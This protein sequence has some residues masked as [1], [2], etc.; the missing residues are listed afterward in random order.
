MRVVERGVA[1]GGLPRGSGAPRR[2]RAA[3]GR[4]RSR[5]RA[6]SGSPRRSAAGSGR[7][8]RRRR[9]R[10]P[11]SPGAACGGSSCPG[12][13]PARAPRSSASSTVVLLDVE[14]GVEGADPDPQLVAGGE[15]TSRSRRA[16]SG[17][18]S[19]SRGPR[20][21]RRGGPRGRARAARRAA[22][23]R[24]R[25]QHRGASRA[26]RRR[27]AREIVPRS[28]STAIAP[29]PLAGAARPFTLAVSNVG[30]AVAP[31]QLAELAVVEGREGPGEAVA[32]VAVGGVH[33]QRAE[34]LALGV[35]QAQSPA[36]TR[37]GCRRPRSGA[38]RSRS[39][40]RPARRRPS[41]PARGRPP[42]RRSW[43]RRSAR[44][45]CRRAASAR[46]RAWSLAPASTREGI[47]P[48]SAIIRRRVRD[49]RH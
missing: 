27:A 45:G 17:G 28:V 32:G 23:S 25:G 24:R 30:V 31:E 47:R 33:D 42:A 44:R 40:R 46:R 4:G 41:R 3:R 1:R 35:H 9:R 34:A 18:R 15:A 12:S 5:S 16:R 14:A 38:R 11:R 7:P 6:R 36:A 8:S 29:S 49:R 2:R 19:R 39:G 21:C 26:R 20:R 22:G 10:R 43:R 48:G 37:S 13:G